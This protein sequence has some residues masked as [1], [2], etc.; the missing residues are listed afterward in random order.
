MTS[1]ST[2][3]SLI[4]PDAHGVT[5]EEA[6]QE[7]PLSRE[8]ASSRWEAVKR[9]REERGL[10]YRPD[11]RVGPL[12]LWVEDH[13]IAE[14]VVVDV[15][16]LHGVRGA[17]IREEGGDLLQLLRARVEAQHQPERPVEASREKTAAGQKAAAGDEAV[18]VHACSDLRVVEH[19]LARRR[20]AA[21]VAEDADRG[22]RLGLGDEIAQRAEHHADVEQAG[23]ER[24]G[25][26]REVA[27]DRV[28]SGW[29]TTKVSWGWS[30]ATTAYPREASS[31]TRPV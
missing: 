16:A 31:I 19:R 11:R 7:L 6:H 13:E 18:E 2:A 27:R 9:A 4:A 17:H 29:S 10:E 15:E 30:N 25:V 24:G 1:S 26:A 28:P 22:V 12:R 8:R 3:S 20:A 23:V 14:A 5:V 21:G